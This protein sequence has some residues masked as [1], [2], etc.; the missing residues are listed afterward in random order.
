MNDILSLIIGIVFG[1][2]P[3]LGWRL[4]FSRPARP[5]KR[6]NRVILTIILFLKF[7]LIGFILYLL[8]LL[9]W[10]NLN[11]FVI[12]LAISPLLVIALVLRKSS[13]VR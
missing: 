4:V 5:G 13:Y 2:L 10:L 8:S 9:P 1:L 7:I 11:L 6:L 12:G 3:F